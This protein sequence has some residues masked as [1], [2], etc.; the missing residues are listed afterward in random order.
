MAC[1]TLKWKKFDTKTLPRAWMPGQAE[2]LGE[3]GLGQGGDQEPD[4]H[5]ESSRVPL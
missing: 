5:S 3:K 2:Q 1:I 4:S